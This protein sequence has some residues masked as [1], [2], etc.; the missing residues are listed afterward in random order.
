MNF[1]CLRKQANV[2]RDLWSSAREE[3][4]FGNQ[5]KNKQ[6]THVEDKICVF[7]AKT[8]STHE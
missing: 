2:S 3:T 4:G 7:T 5:M 1:A 8:E 6:E